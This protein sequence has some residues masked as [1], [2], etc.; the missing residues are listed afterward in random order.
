MSCASAEAARL[1]LEAGMALRLEHLHLVAQLGQRLA[2]TVVRAGDVAWHFAA[3]AAE[4]TV[5]RQP[6]RLA[7]DVPGGDVH[8]GGNAHQRLPRP[9]LLVGQALRRQREQLLV[10]PFRRERVGTQDQLGDTAAQTLDDRSDGPIAGGKPDALDAFVGTHPHQQLV[11]ARHDEVTDP[12]RAPGVGR[13]QDVALELSDLHVL[14]SSAATVSKRRQSC[15]AARRAALESPPQLARRTRCS[16]CPGR[17]T[18]TGQRHRVTFD[19]TPFAATRGTEHDRLGRHG[20]DQL[21]VSRTARTGRVS[22]SGARCVLAADAAAVSPGPHQSVPAARRGRLDH[23]RH[24]DPR[25]QDPRPVGPGLRES[26]R[27]CARSSA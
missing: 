7:D 10:E 22:R 23:R 4:Q 9:A 19:A 12:V 27:R 17:V 2:V 24:R 6:R 11:G 20:R 1:G 5:Q 14:V 26:V 21:P 16:R 8:G 3:V 15:R 18:S 13:A 25:T